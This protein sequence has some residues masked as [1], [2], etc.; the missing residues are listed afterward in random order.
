MKN[1]KTSTRIFSE[2]HIRE[3]NDKLSSRFKFNL[4]PTSTTTT[5]HE[6]SHMIL[7]VSVRGKQC[8]DQTHR[9]LNILHAAEFLPKYTVL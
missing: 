9:K 3:L 2:I 5:L 7:Q 6:D 4:D 1:R 8:F